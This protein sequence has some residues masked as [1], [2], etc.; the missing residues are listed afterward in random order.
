MSQEQLNPCQNSKVSEMSTFAHIK[1]P[2]TLAELNEREAFEAEMRCEEVWGHRSLEKRPDGRYQNWQV[3]AMWDV[4]QARAALS[5]KGEP[6]ARVELMTA[7]GNAG[8]AT[9]I[10]E[11]DVPSRERLRHGTKLYT[12]QPAPAKP[13]TRKQAMA[14]V[15]SNPDTMT[16]I[17]M[18]EAHHGI[19]DKGGA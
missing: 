4:W 11:I 17:R 15:E 6:V 2:Y 5:P 14:I 19:T 8:I 13:M 12:T 7:G 3:N 9:R 10:V 16:A 1:A 18:T